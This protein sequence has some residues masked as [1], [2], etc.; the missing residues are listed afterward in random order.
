METM[1]PRW[2]PDE[3]EK[4]FANELDNNERAQLLSMPADEMQSQ[5]ERMYLA[6]QF[7][8]SDPSQLQG[9]PGRRGASP[10]ASPPDESR[11]SGDVR[12]SD[13]GERRG[14]GRRRRDS[15]R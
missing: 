9:E 4:F 13:D 14:D 11:R 12:S 1:Q 5:L 3:L 15:D 8:L 7:G 2:G 6:S 10:G